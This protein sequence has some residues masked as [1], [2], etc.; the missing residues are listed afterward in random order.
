MDDAV[1]RP[2]T[3]VQQRRRGQASLELMLALIVSMLFIVASTKTWLFF[4]QVIVEQQQCYNRS[5]KAAGQNSDPGLALYNPNAFGGG[6][7][8]PY[9]NPF[10][11]TRPRLTIFSGPNQ[12]PDRC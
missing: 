4:V 12:V 11:M 10:W 9:G 3:T 8:P 1:M 2:Q 7:P 5:R 6:P